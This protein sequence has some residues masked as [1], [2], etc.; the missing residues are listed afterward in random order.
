MNEAPTPMLHLQVILSIIKFM[1]SLCQDL[2]VQKM[3]S[4]IPF[5]PLTI[6]TS[7]SNVKKYFLISYIKSFIEEG[8]DVIHPQTGLRIYSCHLAGQQD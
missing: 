3:F 8:T 1:L 6:S 5:Y 4:S 7:N 2:R